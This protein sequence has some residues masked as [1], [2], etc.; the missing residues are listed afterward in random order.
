MLF[1]ETMLRVAGLPAV[2]QFVIGGPSARGLVRRFVAGET[3][4]EALGAV[5]ELNADGASAT[6]NLLGEDV[7]DLAGADRARDE[8][9][10]Q[11]AAIAAARLDANISVKLTQLGLTFDRSVA[12]KNLEAVVVRA[13]EQDCFV[14]IDMESSTYT[15]VTLDLFY[16]LFERYQNVGVVIQAYLHRGSSDVEELIRR[17]ARVRLVKG[18]YRE[19]ATVAM[20]RKQD[21]DRSFARLM[22]RLVEHGR[23]PALATHDSRLIQYA[24][25]QSHA[26]GIG[27]ERF[28]FQMLYGIR[29]D[30]QADVRRRG[31]GLR[32]Y[33]P[34]GA[35]WYPYF[36]RRLAE[37]PANLLFLLS[38]VLHE[39]RDQP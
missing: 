2:E 33:V 16:A 13:A 35:E 29:R 25:G 11:L 17:Q 34:Y 28:E 30:L 37:R 7:S 3:L 24:I 1:R 8:Y 31:F 5:R 9:I 15:Q 36:S 10:R 32:V 14:R 38:S 23:F 12:Q 6:L 27:R 19:P 26:R 22:E 18:A 4:S 39:A 21:V 20:Q